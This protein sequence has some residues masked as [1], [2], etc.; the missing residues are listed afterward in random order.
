M[1]TI[2]YV[3]ICKLIDQ[4]QVLLWAGDFLYCLGLYVVLQCG[5]VWALLGACEVGLGFGQHWANV[6]S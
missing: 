3:A 6:G 1:V 5:V 2:W 4:L